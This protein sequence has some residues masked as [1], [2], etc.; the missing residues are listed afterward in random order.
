M[1]RLIV[2]FLAALFIGYAFAAPELQRQRNQASRFTFHFPLVTTGKRITDPGTV[3]C[4]CEPYQDDTSPNLTAENDCAT[5]EVVD[6][7]TGY[8]TVPLTATELNN[9]FLYVLCT[10]TATNAPDM[11]FTVTTKFLPP[12]V[13]GRTLDVSVGGEATVILGNTAH[14][15]GAASITLAD[16]GDFQGAAG[17]PPDLL[18]SGVVASLV[19][20]SEF[21]CTGCGTDDGMYNGCTIKV[22]DQGTPAQQSWSEIADFSSG[23]ITINTDY[24]FTFTIQDGD[25]IDILLD[26]CGAASKTE[27]A[28]AV[29][30]QTI[31][32]A[33]AGSM[34]E[35]LSRIPNAAPGGSGGL[36]TVD[37]SNY[38]A[39]I[40]G[41]N[42]T[43]DDV[44]A[45]VPTDSDNALA[46]WEFGGTPTVDLSGRTISAVSGAVGSVT[47]NVGGLAAQAQADVRTAVGLASD[48]LDTQLAALPT[49]PEI[50]MRV[51][52]RMGAIICTVESVTNPENFGCDITEPRTGT[53]VTVQ[54]ND[55]IGMRARIY[56]SASP[57]PNPGEFATILASTR[58]DPNNA[59]D[60]VVSAKSVGAPASPGFSAA[61][62]VGDVLVLF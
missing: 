58:D 56:S 50:A 28:E 31:T 24:P 1:K 30:D 11:T 3:D 6:A 60:V 4:N 13:E 44:V 38:I 36:P 49:D 12:T 40:Q 14:G 19:S 20:Q 52:E 39:G 34:G 43:L 41:S 29:R 33:S 37:I 45:Q 35:R 10:S 2:F 62:A 5:A 55:Y 25:S 22:T 16:Y 53:A 27:L 47:G 51:L 42:N 61:P 21:A 32:G 48:N 7:T 26:K 59:L 17:A 15:G 9:D 46:V 57:P 8:V 54:D 23:V 18:G